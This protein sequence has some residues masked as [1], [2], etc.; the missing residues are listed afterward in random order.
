MSLGAPKPTTFTVAEVE[1][2][3]PLANAI[4]RDKSV[5]A[6]VK[7]QLGSE[8]AKF[9]KFYNQYLAERK[10]DLQARRGA[11]QQAPSY[12]SSSS[13]PSHH[14]VPSSS[15]A[16]M[17]GSSSTRVSDDPS[18]DENSEKELFDRLTL[19][20]MAEKITSTEIFIQF[21]R[22]RAKYGRFEKHALAVEEG[23]EAHCRAKEA[24]S[25]RLK[26]MEL[27]AARIAALQNQASYLTQQM[28]QAEAE[29]RTRA[30]HYA[31][32]ATPY[33]K[34]VIVPVKAS[35]PLKRPT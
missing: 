35:G 29:L 25:E 16:V 20:L 8:Y 7:T 1:K 22:D 21:G 28:H 14:S 3:R 27:S 26:A 23:Y 6:E 11:A 17:S 5:L 31:D 10:A 2:Y 4:I 34:D 32:L 19:E 15:P 33:M 13:S 24:E 30:K 18:A 12:S 9:T